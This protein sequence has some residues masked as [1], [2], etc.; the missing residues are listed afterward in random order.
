MKTKLIVLIV[1]LAVAIGGGATAAVVLNTPE[2]VA[3]RAISGLADDFLERD[4]LEPIIDTFG[5]GSMD[6][7]LTGVNGNGV[8]LMADSHVKGKFYFS[9]EAFMLG[10]FDLKLS[11]NEYKGEAYISR[12]VIYVGEEKVLGG[13]YGVDFTTLADDFKHSIFAP[14]SDSYY[15]LD[16]DSYDLY[17][18]MFESLEENKSFEKDARKLLKTLG[19]DFFEIIMDNA[20]ISSESAKVRVGGKRS[21][22]R[23]VS[24]VIDDD[25][26]KDIIDDAYEYLCESDDIWEF[27]EEHGDLIYSSA[28]GETLADVYED[29][30]RDLDGTLDE[31]YD[32][33]DRYF[34]AIEID[35]ATPKMSAKLLKLEVRCNDETYL[36]LDC[37]EDGIKK[38]D[39]I[40][41]ET[42][43]S[44]ITY[45]VSEDDRNEFA[46]TLEVE[47][48]DGGELLLDIKVDKKKDKFSFSM[49]NSVDDSYVD[50]T[51]DGSLGKKG[52]VYTLTADDFVM[53]LGVG[54]FKISEQYEL[55][56]KLIVDTKDKMPSPK[57]DFKTISDITE[58]QLG[59][60]E[61]KL[62]YL[63]SG[64]GACRHVDAN[65]DGMCDK[66]ITPF[67]DGC[68]NHRDADDDGICDVQYCGKEFFD[69]CDRIHRD[70]DDDGRCDYGGE[71]LSH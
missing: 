26:L 43:Y 49:R 20:D 65:D 22:V 40:K 39:E 1:T 21:G 67:T 66:C 23:L 34:R 48:T 16:R 19:K 14:G 29:W 9:D 31:L 7:S 56:C 35:I 18:D 59:K 6:F 64:G 25:A 68:H 46:A 47:S 51:L 62:G 4:E 57:K 55:E 69:G 17:M 38:T 52:E 11:D 27:I 15:E 24:I 8:E 60:L 71:A 63:F 41:V 3:G 13:T 2:N 61:S 37:G 50:Y 33:I 12:D 53:E 28:D 44:E 42:R 10:D 54:D 45:K 70:A 5:G 36:T 30:L 58:A 32:E